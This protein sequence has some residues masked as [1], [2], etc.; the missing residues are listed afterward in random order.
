MREE[1]RATTVCCLGE[2]GDYGPD[3]DLLIHQSKFSAICLHG[4]SI[5][6]RTSLSSHFFSNKKELHSSHQ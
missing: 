3:W 4:F 2:L 5:E 6:F 1:V